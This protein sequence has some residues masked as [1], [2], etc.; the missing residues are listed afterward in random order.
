VERRGDHGAAPGRHRE[1]RWDP[2]PIV[3]PLRSGAPRPSG[4]SSRP[5]GERWGANSNLVTGRITHSDS[6]RFSPLRN[7]PYQLAEL[8]GKVVKVA[9]GDLLVDLINFFD[10]L[11][12][13][14]LSFEAIRKA[15]GELLN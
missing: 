4:A 8:F 11:S 10:K 15:N 9:T 7:T 6:S 13:S 2:V 1:R 14:Y 3:Q 12:L 5:H